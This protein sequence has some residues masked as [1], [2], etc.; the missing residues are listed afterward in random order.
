[1]QR[2]YNILID[3]SEYYKI[4]NLNN[5]FIILGKVA[6][7]ISAGDEIVITELVF[8]GLFGKLNEK[9]VCAI[10]SMFVC[11]ENGKEADKARI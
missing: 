5:K 2:Y 4:N 6:C 3:I 11:D 9:E 8:S 10:L 7:E 1:M